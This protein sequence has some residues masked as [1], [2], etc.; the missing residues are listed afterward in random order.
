MVLSARLTWVRPWKR[1]FRVSFLCRAS[2]RASGLQPERQV[3]QTRPQGAVAKNLT[4]L[5][6]TNRYSST[7]RIYS[8]ATW[9]MR[10]MTLLWRHP[11]ISILAFRISIQ[12]AQHQMAALRII[13]TA[14][15]VSIVMIR[16]LYTTSRPFSSLAR[17]TRPGST[18]ASRRCSPGKWNKA[19]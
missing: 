6:A 14:W 16:T 11:S 19:T 3:G 17:R 5:I 2:L 7:T 8:A 18:W 15:A 10:S 9:T 1:S 4:T 13:L 12:S